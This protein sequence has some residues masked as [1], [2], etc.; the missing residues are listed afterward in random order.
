MAAGQLRAL[1]PKDLAILKRELKTAGLNSA[2]RVAVKAAIERVSQRAIT[3][4]RFQRRYHWYLSQTLD[5]YRQVG[6][7]N[8]RWDADAETA[9]LLFSRE[10]AR[11][12]FDL[13]NAWCSQGLR[14]IRIRVAYAAIKALHEGCRDPL[15]AMILDCNPFWRN[16][17]RSWAVRRRVK[18]DLRALMA[19]RYSAAM[20]LEFS[21]AAAYRCAAVSNWK[22]AE[23]CGLESVYLISRV[24][25][26]P[27]VPLSF[28]TSEI[29]CN[30]AALVGPADRDHAWSRANAMILRAIDVHHPSPTLRYL[31]LFFR[32]H[33]LVSGAWYIRGNGFADTVSQKAS[34]IFD[35]R[36]RSAR[37][38]LREAYELMPK[39]PEAPREMITVDLG[40]GHPR[41]I[42]KWFKR[43]MQADPDDHQACNAMLWALHRRW[44]GSAK[45]M[46]G[47]GQWCVHYGHWNSRIPLLAISALFAI[48]THDNYVLRTGFYNIYYIVV[49]H[50][51]WRKRSVWKL[52]KAAI[53]GYFRHRP[54]SAHDLGVDLFLCIWADKWK[55]ALNL[56]RSYDRGP[57]HP[58]MERVVQPFYLPYA[59]PSAFRPLACFAG[60]DAAGYYFGDTQYSMARL[61]REALLRVQHPSSLSPWSVRRRQ[62]DSRYMTWA[63]RVTTGALDKSAPKQVLWMYVADRAMHDEAIVLTRSP[64]DR[65]DARDQMIHAAGEAMGDEC[66]NPLILFFKSY[67]TISIMGPDALNSKVACASASRLL[68]GHFP[69]TDQFIAATVAARIAYQEHPAGVTRART[70]LT[71]ALHL[72]PEFLHDTRIP[73]GAR[74]KWCC[75]LWRDV[76]TERKSPVAA[77]SAFA[78]R[79][80]AAHAQPILTSLIQAW[81]SEQFG[82]AML[83]GP[84]LQS[85]HQLK[86][87]EAGLYIAYM[88]RAL[89]EY[90][91]AWT[92]NPNCISAID[93]AMTSQFWISLRLRPPYDIWPEYSTWLTRAFDADP[94]ALTACR[95]ATNFE[96]MCADPFNGKWYFNNNKFLYELIRGPEYYRRPSSPMNLMLLYG[97]Q[98]ILNYP[99]T[100]AAPHQLV[101]ISLIHSYHIWRHLHP[102]MKGYFMYHPF[103]ERARSLYAR[104]ACELHHWNTAERQFQKLG[105]AARV[106]VF[107]GRKKYFKL[108]TEASNHVMD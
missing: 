98:T 108:K 84:R 99:Q 4:A 104:V 48:Q 74:F 8:P 34:H 103:D 76:A 30:L 93:G 77:T 14:L 88:R 86:P 20:K 57:R 24:V 19:S 13:R 58:A 6:D 28:L 3:E 42:A 33:S 94:H 22:A 63:S 60:V 91:R 46:F 17:V 85:I 64:R 39:Q 12:A 37:R 66:R 45:L 41:R 50:R 79:L 35:L 92:M 107:G 18:G 83:H 31:N 100:N 78:P 87:R 43:T 49:G 68:K 106:S 11:P 101:H 71:D 95:I 62:R 9:L 51:F 72:L 96:A 52:A 73:L 25:R 29:F 105:S 54:S 26:E 89:A 90:H 44:Y 1:P 61:Y 38:Y 2:A 15:I 21:T 80:T 27:K 67:N 47:F 82:L 40:L 32:G 10:Q 36:L 102:A 56:L 55:E 53:L 81:E 5:A 16:G 59:G 7:H 75:R 97:A 23:A 70:F 65:G 69:L